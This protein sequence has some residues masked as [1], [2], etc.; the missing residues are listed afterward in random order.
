MKKIAIRNG[1]VNRSNVGA[2]ANERIRL[3]AYEL[4]EQ[5][6]R[7]QGHE[8]DDWLLAEK[9]IHSAVSRAHPRTS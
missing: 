2:D 5:R 9:E 8:M 6:G 3:R 1:S 7:E 4:F